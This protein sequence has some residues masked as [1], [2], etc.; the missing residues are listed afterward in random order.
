VLALQSLRQPPDSAESQYLSLIGRLVSGVAHDFN[1]LLTG[2]LLYC[3]LLGT[4]AVDPKQFTAK[5]EEIRAAAEKGAGLI[6]QLMTIGRE[7]KDSPSHVSFPE[8]LQD[9]LPLLRHLSGENIQIQ[10]RF[11]ARAGVVPISLAQAQQIVLNLVLNSRDAMPEGGVVTLEISSHTSA[12]PGAD[13]IFEFKVSDSGK[14]MDSQT[15]ARMFEPFFTT[16]ARGRGTGMGLA[17]VRRIVEE[18]GGTVE[19]KSAP[20]RGTC[21]TVRLPELDS[22]GG[23]SPQIRLPSTINVSELKGA[24]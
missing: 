2:I 6:R 10:T 4:T 18:A 15:A 20:G 16:K 24:L 8:A 11:D 14:G 7:E 1:N 19:V 22:N 23:E 12:Q 9:V 17:T 5:I 3:D 21:M 13:R